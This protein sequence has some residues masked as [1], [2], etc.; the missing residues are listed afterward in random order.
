MPKPPDQ[1]K[2]YHITHVDNL[3]SIIEAGRLFS[4]AK[5]IE[6]GGP[7][8]T[9]GMSRIKQ[10]R[11][12]LP[13]TCQPGTHVG[14][15][16][17]FYFCPRS[18]MLYKIHMGNDPEL[19]YRGGQEPIVHLEA[20][21]RTVVA[22]A[23]AKGRLWAF[24]LSN[25]GARYTEFRSDLKDLG[26]INWSAVTARKWGGPGVDPEIRDGKQAEFL[27][28]GSFPWKLLERIG[29]RS[30]ALAQ[31]VADALR[32]ADHRPQVEVHPDWYY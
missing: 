12:E 28:R 14:D 29:V 16:V 30:K 25:A 20:D 27:I 19:P 9:I 8:A 3:P 21:L 6:E 1:P 22:R 7:S 5:M 24:S 26:E 17:P 15:Y 23:N 13:V 11:L 2:I 31:Q 18:I 10:R 32:Q 4:D